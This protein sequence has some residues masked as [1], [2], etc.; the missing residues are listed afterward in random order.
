MEHFEKLALDSAQHR[1]SLWLQYVDDTFVVWPY[2]PEQ[3]QNFLS[4]L[5]SL[6]LSI[7][8]SVETESDSAIAFLDVLAIRKETTLAD[9]S[10]SNITI[11]RTWKEA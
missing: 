2:D 5:S 9:I 6:R 8:F 3:L 1:P 7:Q 10:T 4:Q 11:H